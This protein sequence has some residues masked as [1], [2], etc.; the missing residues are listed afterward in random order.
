MTELQAL[1]AA[2]A[3][4]NATVYGYGVAGARLRGPDRDYAQDALL[5]HL[6]LRDRLIALVT[7]RGAQPVAAH[8]AYQLPFAVTNAKTARGLAA[9]L[10]ESG[11][12]AAWDLVEASPPDGAVRSLGIGWLTDA[13]RRA[14]HWGE[15][16]A[17][18]GQPT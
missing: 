3:A 15:R 10:E 12:G 2:L 9:H 4:E 17:L 6:R 7:A 14:V 11:A 8:S 16:Q 13:A 5:D 18:P 1:Q